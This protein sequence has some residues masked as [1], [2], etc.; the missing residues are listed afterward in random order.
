M[1]PP[2]LRVALP[3]LIGVSFGASLACVALAVYLGIAAR[4]EALHKATRD[5]AAQ[6]DMLARQIDADVTLF[7][8]LLRETSRQAPLYEMGNPP[9]RSPLLEVP[10]TAQYLSF[11]NVLNEVGD[12]VA[13]PRSNVS[14][15]L[16]FGGRDYF[17]DH[18]DNP[19]DVL[20]IGRPFATAPN[21][22]ASIPISRRLAK[23]DGSFGGVVVAG[24][25]LSWLS[26]LLSR[27]TAGPHPSIT[28]HR[29]DG[30][31]L[32]RF[33]LDPDAIGRSGASDPTWMAWS[34]AGLQPNTDDDNGIR[35]F[36][37]LNAPLVVDLW[38]TPADLAAGERSWGLW[39]PPLALVPGLG[40]LGLGLLARRLRHDS[41]QIEAAAQDAERQR[42]KVMAT[43]SHELRTPLTGV[44]GQ[45]E[46][47]ADEGGLSDSQTT[48]LTLLTNA[49]LHMRT[50]V[51]RV[52]D[53]VRMGGNFQPQ[54]STPC[55]LDRLVHTCGGNVEVEARA[56]GLPLM[57]SIDPSA[58][59]R[60]MLAQDYVQRML[61]NLLKNAVKF[62]MQGSVTLRVTG[63]TKH[64]RF[65]VADTGP[66]IPLAKRRRLFQENDRLDAPAQIPGSGLGLWTAKGLVDVMGGTIGYADNPGGGSLFWTELPTSLPAEPAFAS[67]DA[68][69]P[70]PSGKTRQ[71]SILLADDS[72]ITRGVTVD[73]LRSAGHTVTEVTD[74]EAAIAEVQK[75]DFDVLLTDMRMP[76]TDGLE[77]TRR[78]RALR[79]N[80]GQ[81][82]IVLV[83]ADMSALDR[84]A[85]SQTGV[86]VCLKKPFNRV[87]LLAAVDEA[88]RLTP[89]REA[90]AW[91][92]PAPDGNAPG[93][94]YLGAATCRI[95][96]LL[97]SLEKPGATEDPM[98]RETVHELVG[99]TGLL[100]FT[101]LS[102]SLRQFDIA[103]RRSGPAS[104]R[105]GAAAAAI[106]ALRRQLEPEQRS[107][108]DQHSA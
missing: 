17:K 2:Q 21:Q 34:R 24:V 55:D 26:D 105:C 31:I 106:Q 8:Q 16:N 101:S 93:A 3:W 22:H 40:V 73:F 37:R 96:E 63:D 15:S 92:G 49:G 44:L 94:G 43:L 32:A 68:A 84:E 64:L 97:Q 104:E 76:V 11:I 1:R 86:D 23:P 14:R 51:D 41:D 36:R 69:L 25:H 7:D 98:V 83:T 66:G 103:L 60:V 75:R 56:K 54:V 35:L 12:V 29:D 33:P 52:T 27:A 87:E 10:L 6:A 48:K 50:I 78:I 108:P 62:T 81:T 88:A 100:G 102:Q 71:L 58:P 30:L 46:M 38:L 95:E 19:A 82:P 20:M 91:A 5:M 77:A 99:V 39:L 70:T 72:D 4:G 65:E 67:P 59:R 89:V 18:A 13:D 85:T 74:G 45:A 28:I 107:R 79:G 9:P 47:I 61:N 80:R 57:V 42:A 90:A 53:S